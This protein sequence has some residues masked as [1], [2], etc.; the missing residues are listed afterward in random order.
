MTCKYCEISTISCLHFVNEE[1]EPGGKHLKSRAWLPP[2]RV[3]RPVLFLS[4]LLLLLWLGIPG[5]AS[6]K[7]LPA[8]L[9]RRSGFNPW[10]GR[11]PGEGNV[12]PLQYSCL[13]NSMDR[14]AW[15][16]IVHEFTELDMTEATWCAHSFISFKRYEYLKDSWYILIKCFPGKNWTLWS[17]T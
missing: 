9:Y 17:A 13:G 4:L 14:G 6:G 16:A 11:C 3:L 1:T 7:N 10:S 12:Y 2:V 15:Q 5:G 8:Y